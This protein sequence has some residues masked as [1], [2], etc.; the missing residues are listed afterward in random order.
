MR[1]LLYNFKKRKFSVR[2]ARI[3]VA[4]RNLVVVKIAYSA[5]C[6]T[7]L[8]VMRGIARPKSYD[9]REIILGHAWTGSV[10]TIGRGVKNLR[11]GQKVYGSDYAPCGRC[12][13]CK[14]GKENLCEHRFIPGIECP[15]THRE[16][17]L[18]PANII[19][20]LPR[21]VGPEEGCLLAD[22]LGVAYHAIHCADFSKNSTIGIWGCGPIGLA[23]GLL[24]KK[25]YGVKKI[26]I[27]EPSA[28]RR[29]LAKRIFQ[30]KI[31]H[32]RPS[33]FF[34]N[35]FDVAYE[36]SGSN[37]AFHDAF[38]NIKRG[39]DLVILGIYDQPSLLSTFKLL[40]RHLRISGTFAYS[41]KDLDAVEKIAARTLDLSSLITH[42]FPLEKAD[43]AYRLFRQK[44]TGAVLLKL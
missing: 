10:A 2:Q 12:L 15:G 6:G 7:D 16:Y 21:G 26:F 14:M 3:P 20:P 32:N 5:L 24:L 11:V 35:F 29:R 42:V 30:P 33:E 40:T 4:K 1:E 18:L 41:F 25:V 38:H 8:H 31:F 19:R 43:V 13:E 39:G 27:A 36:A 22:V 9:S 37:A 17:A 34:V 44:Q 23:A 28:Y